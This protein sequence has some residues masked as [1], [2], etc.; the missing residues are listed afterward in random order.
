MEKPIDQEVVFDIPD[1]AQYESYG[2][3]SLFRVTNKSF[4]NGVYYELKLID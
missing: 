3:D 1:D 2:R 4:A